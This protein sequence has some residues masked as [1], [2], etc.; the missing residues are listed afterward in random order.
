MRESEAT[1]SEDSNSP[2]LRSNSFSWQYYKPANMSSEWIDDFDEPDEP[3]LQETTATKRKSF[4]ES[5][6][7]AEANDAKK[8]AKLSEN[9]QNGGHART[10]SETERKQRLEIEALKRQLE[11]SKNATSSTT[12]VE[13]V[14]KEFHLSSKRKV[15]V[16]DF[17]G[18]PLVDIREFYEKDGEMAPGRKGISLTI[19]QYN[20]LK[21]YISEI[22]KAIESL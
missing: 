16:R 13:D 5:N 21:S 7:V 17:R 2:L 22:D 20:K 4:V 9:V 10:E 8:R 6:A 14:P 18:K 19:D 15:T 1:A 3:Q 11:A 12:K